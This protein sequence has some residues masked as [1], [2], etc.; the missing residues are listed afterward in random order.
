MGCIPFL[1]VATH[2]PMMPVWTVTAGLVLVGVG[3]RIPWCH[4]LAISSCGL[5][6]IGLGAYVVRIWC[7]SG[8]PLP[9]G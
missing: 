8:H 9:C 2:L 4:L 3:P 5:V 7:E 6:T 1:P